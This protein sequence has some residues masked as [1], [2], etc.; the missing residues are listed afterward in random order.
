[1]K[2]IDYQLIEKEERERAIEEYKDDIAA[3]EQDGGDTNK[4]DA[5]RAQM[6]ML[7]DAKIEVTHDIIENATKNLE[8]EIAQLMTF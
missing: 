3:Q 8:R 7:I 5:S 4:D 1:M 6:E 2:F